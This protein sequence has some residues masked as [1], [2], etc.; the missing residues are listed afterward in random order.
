MK[1]NKIYIE[2]TN[3]CN[4]NC[5]FC[6]KDSRVKHEM[7]IDEFEH[8]VN[9][10]KEYTDSIYLHVKGEPLLNPNL[11]LFL[12]ICEKNNLQITKIIYTFAETKSKKD[13]MNVLGLKFDFQIDK[14]ISN[15]YNFSEDKL[16]GYLVLLSDLDY[17]IKRGK[18][19]NKLAL[20]MFI[21]KICM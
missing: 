14:L 9:E 16:E 6:S 1:F 20:E 10:I 19:S 3:Y 11:D 21:M 7:T 18:I 5:S 8:I 15:S 2:I 13:M 4:L 12:D 17:K